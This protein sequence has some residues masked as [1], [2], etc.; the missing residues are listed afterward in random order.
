[1]DENLDKLDTKDFSLKKILSLK[2]RKETSEIKFLDSIVHSI[3]TKIENKK[4]NGLFFFEYEVPN[5][6][7]GLPLFD[8]IKI[9]KTIQKKMN[10]PGILDVVYLYENK[11]YISWKPKEKTYPHIPVILERIKRKIMISASKENDSC[12]Y[13]IPVFIAGFPMYDSDEAAKMIKKELKG[14]GLLCKIVYN[15]QLFISWN[16]KEI[17]KMNNIEIK[18][19]TEEEKRKKQKE[20]QANFQ[21]EKYKKYKNPERTKSDFE[22]E[23]ETETEE[24]LKNVYYDSDEE[25]EKLDYND[26]FNMEIQSNPSKPENFYPEAASFYKYYEHLPPLQEN[27]P[28]YSSNYK[29]NTRTFFPVEYT[30]PIPVSK[31][32][33]ESEK[34]K[35]KIR[36]KANRLN[37]FSNPNRMKDTKTITFS[38]NYISQ[39]NGISNK[40]ADELDSLKSEVSKIKISKK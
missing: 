10:N 29:A 36:R 25:S 40:F 23:T 30:D 12:I 17:E 34:R 38:Q 2:K 37:K 19:R 35:Q 28:N 32:K 15:N 16:V 13:E 7:P 21:K 27:R 5:F 6:I 9:A 4:R 14:E 1:M 20:E 11:L 3:N 22:S 18:F 24:N 8:S 31:V 39:S 33:F 26:Y